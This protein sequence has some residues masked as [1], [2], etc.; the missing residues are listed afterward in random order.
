MKWNISYNKWNLCLC[1]Y[2]NFEDI[3]SCIHDRRRKHYN[4]LSVWQIITCGNDKGKWT[5]TDY[6]AQIFFT[7]QLNNATSSDCCGA[8]VYTFP[9]VVLYL[10]RYLFRSNKIYWFNSKCLLS[11]SSVPDMFVVS[12]SVSR[13]EG[14]DISVRCL[15]RDQW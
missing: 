12:S 4:P 7:V 1:V 2:S 10:S 6:P 11:V 8:T 15:Y 5:I 14:G 9:Y 3:R 13:H